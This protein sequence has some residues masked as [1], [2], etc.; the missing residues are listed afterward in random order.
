MNETVHFNK[1]KI[2]ATI[3]PATES[4]EM[5]R[6][7]LLAGVDVCRIN[8]SHGT[9]EQH[10]AVIKNVHELNQELDLNTSI[11]GD[12]QGPKLRIGLVEND[13]IEI[14]SGNTILCTNKEITG[15]PEKLYIKYDRLTEDLRPGERILI[16]DGKI[17]LVVESIVDANTIRA[18]VE[19]GGKVMSR[20]GFNLPDSDLTV[21]A[22][23]PKDIVDLEFAIQHD[24]DWIGLSFVRKATDID[25]VRGI[26]NNRRGY[27]RIIAKIE[28]PQAVENIDDIVFAA[29]AIMVARGDLGV[30]LPMERVP[31]IQKQIVEK[32][33][34]HSR[35]VIIATQMMESM[36]NSPTPTRAETNDV[37]NAVMDGADAVM[38]SAETSVGK[39]PVHAVKAVEKILQSTENE[40]DIYHKG[41][42]PNKLSPTFLSDEICFTAVRISDHIKAKAIISLTYSGYTAFKI[43]A[44]RPNCHIFI[45]TANKGLFRL[46]S[47]VW[48]I[49]VLYYDKMQSTDRTIKDILNLLKEKGLLVEGDLVV[50]TASMPIQEKQRTNTLKI[51]KVD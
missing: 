45:F 49:R 10:A 41:K 28:K 32:C 9:H 21:E 5:L 50:H 2:I 37:A 51:S 3:G 38:L 26:V 34:A 11:L 6:S 47:L 20:K 22:L 13:E 14:T 8:F 31:V 1:T 36:I 16:D 35:P 17:H 43:A 48:N 40:W 25:L 4:K 19:H 24:V 18:R 27:Q 42:K 39:Y 44:F 29:D 23:T 30:E 33:L 7:I 46:L 12:L 15:T